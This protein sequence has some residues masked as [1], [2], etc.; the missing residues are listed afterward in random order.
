MRAVRGILSWILLVL[1]PDLQEEIRNIDP[2]SPLLGSF[3]QNNEAKT[4]PVEQLITLPCAD[5]Y[6]KGVFALRGGRRR[7][8]GLL[9][10]Y[11]LKPLPA[12]RLKDLLGA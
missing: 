12:L 3:A 5:L 7:K 2:N 1:A 10:A 6:P 11:P 4:S 8:G 9:T